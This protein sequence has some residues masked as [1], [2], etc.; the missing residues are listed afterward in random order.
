LTIAALLI[1]PPVGVVLM[2]LLQKWDPIVKAA[3]SVVA[4]TGT[5]AIGAALKAQSQPPAIPSAI[6]HI[7]VPPGQAAGF[8][9]AQPPS[10]IS[11]AVAPSPASAASPATGA[12]PAASNPAASPAPVRQIGNAL[13]ALAAA[14]AAGPPP[15]AAAGSAAPV[16][17]LAATPA[18]AQAA[19]PAPVQQSPAL[20]AAT[21]PASSAPA[22]PAAPS[23]AAKPAPAATP[24]PSSITPAQKTQIQALLVAPV[25]RYEQLLA[26]G[27]QVLGTTRYKDSGEAADALD[28]PKSAAARFSEWRD[29]ANIDDDKDLD[30]A[31]DKVQAIVTDPGDPFST[32]L[33]TWVDNVHD[34]QS[35]LDDWTNV[36]NDWQGRDKT[37]AD[38]ANAEK[39]VQNA[40]AKA[41]AQAGVVVTKL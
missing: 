33:D 12:P 19:P 4:L 16:A 31:I 39:A 11:A 36:A 25:T 17:P 15:S 6:A 40:A 37:D 21:A 14:A 41:R 9:A 8:V 13:A 1:V 24:T 10:E 22:A 5:L 3:V 7:A 34:L 30:S 18:P 29:K 23:A 28:D 26:A 38:L 35:S 20:A 2:W 32:A 27:K